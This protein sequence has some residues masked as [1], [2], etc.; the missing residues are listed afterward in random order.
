MIKRTAEDIKQIIVHCSDS[1]VLGHDNVDTIRDWHLK[2]GF[3]DIGYHYV[4]LKRPHLD[5]KHVRK[6][7]DV[8]LVGAHCQGH[9]EDSIGICLTGRYKFSTDQ[10]TSLVNLLDGLCTVFNIDNIHGHSYFNRN[11]TCP[12]FDHSPM[13][14]ISKNARLEVPR[15]YADN[16]GIWEYDVENILPGI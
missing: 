5:G 15:P 8:F 10:F 16:E 7:R 9:N 2:R 11:K 12:N 1:D 6:G 4:I 3:E 14:D 13:K